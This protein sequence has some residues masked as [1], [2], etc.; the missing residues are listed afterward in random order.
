MPKFTVTHLVPQDVRQQILYRLRQTTGC[1]DIGFFT[2]YYFTYTMKAGCKKCK[3]KI[4]K[5]E[6]RIAKITAS[7]FS[8]DGEMKHYH[9]PACIFETF[10]K[11]RATTKVIEDPSDLEGWQEVEEADKQDILKLIRE[12]ERPSPT[13]TPEGKNVKK[14]VVKSPK[15]KKPKE[16]T[17][18][19]SE[20][21]AG[22]PVKLLGNSYSHIFVQV[23]VRK[24]QFPHLHGK[25]I[26]LI[27]GTRITTSGS[28][29]DCVPT[30][31][32]AQA[33]WT[34]RAL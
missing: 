10:K 25:E 20:S 31:R 29:V 14:T 30:S 16:S 24:I 8:D 34:S 19:S 28:S 15:E 7:P 27:P 21:S 4:E 2:L 9:H 32:T 23:R 13:K 1:F 33:T 12:N 6:I 3:K 5:G 11:A 22:C 18:T 26:R 17:S